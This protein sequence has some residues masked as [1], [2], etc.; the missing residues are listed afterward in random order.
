MAFLSSFIKSLP[1]AEK[2]PYT[3]G[4]DLW[5]HEK[6]DKLKYKKM[7]LEFQKKAAKI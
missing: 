7:V 5:N 2:K 3:S 4:Q 6:K 1:I